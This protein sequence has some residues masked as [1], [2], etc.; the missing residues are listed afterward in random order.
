MCTSWDFNCASGRR[1][2]QHCSSI[3]HSAILN[4][5]TSHPTTHT[6]MSLRISI[7]FGCMYAFPV[8]ISGPTLFHSSTMPTLPAGV[9]AQGKKFRAV[10][11]R[12]A[13]T[14]TGPTRTTSAEAREDAVAFKAG[15]SPAPREPRALPKWVYK[16]HGRF[17]GYRAARTLCGTRVAGHRPCGRCKDHRKEFSKECCKDSCKD[18][19]TSDGRTAS[20]TFGG[21]LWSVPRSR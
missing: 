3:L 21:R 2:V 11:K 6:T 5:R 14:L 18:S 19:A 15:Q 12:G 4:S 7:I 10:V 16:H 1:P 17:R 20:R 13:K 8:V 9:Y